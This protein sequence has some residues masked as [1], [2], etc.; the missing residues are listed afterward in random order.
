MYLLD[1][2]ILINLLRPAPSTNVL[3]CSSVNTVPRATACN[4]RTLSVARSIAPTHADMFHSVDAR[5]LC[6][7]S[8]AIP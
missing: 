8:A 5:T 2:D 3:K 4:R 7:G 1:T 6:N